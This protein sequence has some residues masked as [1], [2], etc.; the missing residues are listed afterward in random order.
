ML[1][2]QEMTLTD[3]EM[4]KY[5][6]ATLSNVISQFNELKKQD[7]IFSLLKYPSVLYNSYFLLVSVREMP[8]INILNKFLLRRSNTVSA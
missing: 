2:W 6:A 3:V 5:I 4:L 7:Y 1:S 8:L